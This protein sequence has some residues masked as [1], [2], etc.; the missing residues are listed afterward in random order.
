[1]IHLFSYKKVS[2]LK[3]IY[4]NEDL[5]QTNNFMETCFDFIYNFNNYRNANMYLIKK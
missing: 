1:M 5:C 3:M 4:F 2:A